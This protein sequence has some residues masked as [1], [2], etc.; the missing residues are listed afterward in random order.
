MEI[1]DDIK[2]LGRERRKWAGGWGGLCTKVK[3][4]KRMNRG[5]EECYKETRKKQEFHK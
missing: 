4:K 3:K 2:G 5:G 1:M